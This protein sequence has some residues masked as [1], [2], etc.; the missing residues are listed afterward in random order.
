MA[1]IGAVAV[2]AFDLHA[3]DTKETRRIFD[4][5]ADAGPDTNAAALPARGNGLRALENDLS[6]P[7]RGLNPNGGSLDGRFSRPA[8]QAIPRQKLKDQSRRNWLSDSESD[9][10]SDPF[11]GDKWNSDWAKALKDTRGQSPEAFTSFSTPTPSSTST[12]QTDQTK[13]NPFGSNDELLP[14]GV[15]DTAS[16]LR[17]LTEGGDS[18]SPMAPRS[19]FNDFFGLGTAETIQAK[20]RELSHKS[21]LNQYKEILNVPTSNLGTPSGTDLFATSPGATTK[22]PITS[23]PPFGT[24][25][26]SRAGFP[27]PQLGM[28][29]PRFTPEA[30]PDINNRVLNSWNPMQGPTAP[31]APTKTA[32]S[33][34][35]TFSLPKRAF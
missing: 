15:R 25:A 29:N 10:A 34:R 17:K 21:Y 14:N 33:T 5:S 4:W 35:A 16:N 20:E 9:P 27:E 28:I 1:A 8:P 3:A 12:R 22:A 18:L 26:K 31:Q 7:F 19:S 30:V 2:G 11:S 6:Q 23:M 13:L 32:A 24:A